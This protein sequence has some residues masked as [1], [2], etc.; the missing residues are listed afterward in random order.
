MKK[1]SELATLIGK[2]VDC[3]KSPMQLD[4]LLAKDKEITVDLVYM[5]G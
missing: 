2:K 1:I 4:T 5:K 3:F